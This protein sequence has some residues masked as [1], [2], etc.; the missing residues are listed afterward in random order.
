MWR[1]LGVK[2]RADIA[3]AIKAAGPADRLLLDAKAPSESPIPGGNGVAFDWR[4][5]QGIAPPL[6]WGLGGGL[7]PGNV[8][9]ALAVVRPAFVDVSS[10][11]EDRPGV[12]SL[13]KIAE[14]ASAVRGA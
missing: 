13:Q 14:F 12:K 8:G 2:S 11:I 4:L 10:G 9:A 7:H 3:Q 6:P 1:A 5:M